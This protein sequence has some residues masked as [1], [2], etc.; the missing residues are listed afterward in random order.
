MPAYGFVWLCVREFLR[1]TCLGM[2]AYAM[3]VYVMGR[4]VRTVSQH[5]SV[6]GV[7]SDRVDG[8][9][10]KWVGRREY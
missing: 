9:T 6:R 8:R 10:R 1:G 5:I 2:R 3:R 4:V 7:V